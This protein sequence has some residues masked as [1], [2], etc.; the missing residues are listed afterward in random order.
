MTPDTPDSQNSA[1]LGDKDLAT[2]VEDA[3]KLL[4]K[5]TKDLNRLK[6]QKARANGGIEVR[7][8]MNLGFVGGDHYIKYANKGLTSENRDANKLYLMFD[9][10]N[11]RLSKV[12]GRLS[13]I[14]PPFRAQPDR[15]D[16]KA[17]EEAEVVDKMI[18]ALDLKLHQDTITWT[19]LWWCAVAGTSFEY[20]PWIENATI[21]PMPVYSDG[22]DAESGG[23]LMFRNTLTGEEIPESQMQRAVNGG[24]VA[25]ESF[26][27]M[28]EAQMT[29]EVGSEVLSPLN[30]FID[31]TVKSVQ[32]LGPDQMV[33]VAKIRTIGWVQE[34]FGVE[35]EPDKDFQIV[36]TKFNVPSPNPES[37]G[38]LLKDLI[39]LV[40]GSNDAS[41]PE[42]CVVVETYTPSSKKNPRGKYTCWVPNKGILHDGDN[43]YGD[44]PLVDFHWKPVTTSFW[45][46][47]YISPL[48][49]PQKFINKRFSQLG[50]QANGSLYSQILLGGSLKASDINADAPGAVENGLAENGQPM[51][52][53]LGPPELPTWFLESINLTLQAFNDIAGGSDLFQE[54]KF[55]GQMRGPMAVPMMQEI[56][57][58]EWG[59]LF[60]HLGERMAR[61]KQMRLDRVKQFYPP[62]RTMHYTDRD[63][64]DEVMTFHTD[65]V[66][67]GSI[68]F[69]VHVDRSSLIPELKA[70]KEQR[71]MNRLS[72]PLAVLYMD[73][74][75]GMLDKS[76][77]AAD[78][79]VGDQG[80]VTREAQY[81]KLGSEIVAM[82]WQGMQVP[83]VLPF[84][85]HRVMMDELEHGMAT[86]EFLK[87]SPTVQKLFADRWEQHRMYLDIEAQQQSAMMNSGMIQSAVAQATQQ[88]AAMAAAEAVHS[89]MGQVGAQKSQP[90]DQ[91]V[92]QAEAS[93]QSQQGPQRPTGRPGAPKPPPGR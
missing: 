10:I 74:R 15:D 30:V 89:A 59:P 83:P 44:I 4:D 73:E 72:G 61:V 69:N 51:V 85:D 76:K 6:S 53:R 79:A 86:T 63:Q 22:G 29:G 92:A 34:T 32:D 5:L 93:A 12:I 67:K 8:L 20:I 48:I 40:Q 42:M 66:L 24:L 88:A 64:R 52:Q 16:P 38:T 9:L 81:R 39:P 84:Y 55:P 46:Q 78:M 2:G 91:Y 25:P 37:G 87:A 11:P 80:R 21:E 26:E 68:N 18:K 14:D 71:V 19:I 41:D 45:T 1:P 43:P 65:K 77:I 75:T 13:S 7:V 70:L 60:S 31:H 62:I 28:E 33:H 49:A 47:D 56:L 3:K 17:W 57:D 36:S 27:V 90:T 54:S 82:L 23:E 58:T 50:E 35:I